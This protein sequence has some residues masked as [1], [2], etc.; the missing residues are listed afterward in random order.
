MAKFLSLTVVFD[1]QNLNYGEGVGNIGALKR[2]SMKGKSF[3]YI[4]RQALRYDMVRIMNEMFNVPFTPIGQ[5]GKVVQFEKD[6]IIKDFPEID[7]FGYMKTGKNCG[8]GK[9]SIRKAPSRLSDAISLEPYNNDLEFG[10]NMGLSHRK[11]D[12][13]NMLFQFE[14]HKSL[15]SYTMTIDLDKIGVDDN[16]GLNLDAGERAQRV[17]YLL[18]AVKILYRD[19][20]GKRENL[21]PQFVIGGIYKAGNPFFYNKIEVSYSKDKCLLNTDKINEALEITISD[22]KIEDDTAIGV[23]TGTFSNTADLKISPVT[24]ENFFSGVKKKVSSHYGS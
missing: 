11:K 6:A 7:L 3:S 24:I 16:D 2:L 17:N 20:R 1:G 13:D 8:N 9:Q 15:Y 21:S 19:I 23:S 22:K 5:D 18:D 4:S 10:N 12:T 14:T